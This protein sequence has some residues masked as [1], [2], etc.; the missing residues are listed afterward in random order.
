MVGMCLF[1][2][3]AVNFARKKKE[4]YAWYS[5]IRYWLLTMSDLP[6][7]STNL[8]ETKDKNLLCSP[9]KMTKDWLFSLFSFRYL[10]I[11]FFYC[12]LIKTIKN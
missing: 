2:E 7:F 9:K 5:V 3:Q 11:S 4:S 10:Y 1:N 6:F 12:Q 8:H